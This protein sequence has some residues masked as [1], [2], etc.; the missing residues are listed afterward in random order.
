MASVEG[1]S[2]LEE[3]SSSQ[4][5]HRIPTAAGQRPSHAGYRSGSGVCPRLTDRA[6]NATARAT[7]RHGLN[8]PKT[9]PNSRLANASPTQNVTYTNVGA[10]LASAL[11]TPAN[12][13]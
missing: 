6:T 4:A 9:L 10:R 11:W 5:K 12:P 2:R 1:S 7:A 8:A 3:T 13:A